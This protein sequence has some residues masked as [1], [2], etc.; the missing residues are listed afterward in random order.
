MMEYIVFSFAAYGVALLLGY[1]I[2]YK[3]KRRWGEN[4]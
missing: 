3:K 2:F 4:P 1:K